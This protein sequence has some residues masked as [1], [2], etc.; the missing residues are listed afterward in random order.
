MLELR[1]WRTQRTLSDASLE[2]TGSPALRIRLSLTYSVL[3]VV[4][5]SV[6]FSAVRRS[7]EDLTLVFVH[8]PRRIVPEG[9][10]AQVKLFRSWVPRGSSVLY[11]MTQP[12]HWQLGLW[13]RS[14]YPDYVVIPVYDAREVTAA[15][16]EALRLRHQAR[17]ALSA[18]NLPTVTGFAWHIRLPDYP[19]GIPILLGRF[20]GNDVGR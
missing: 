4:L 5:G 20:E 2:K 6:L 15:S 1:F 14:L 3:I 10:I 7:Y 8:A 9:H 16:V 17:F 19:S 18:G 12:E 13:Q 11:V